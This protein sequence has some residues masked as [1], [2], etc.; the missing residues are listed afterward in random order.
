MTQKHCRKSTHPPCWTFQD[1]QQNQQLRNCASSA[2]V[3]EGFSLLRSSYRADNSYPLFFR[4]KL[5]YVVCVC[6]CI[7][8][9]AA[10]GLGWRG[11][12]KNWMSC[13]RCAY[14]KKI[15]THF[16]LRRTPEIITS[17]FLLDSFN[18]ILAMLRH[19]R[20]N[21]RHCFKGALQARK[22][23]MKTL[24]DYVWAL[25]D[26]S[27]TQIPHSILQRRSYTAIVN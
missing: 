16:L 11:R 5:R 22:K 9:R 10:A 18:R 8:R 24:E 15:W 21:L 4:L 26:T 12:G 19:K 23:K 17:C 7:S 1:P 20:G 14:P 13:G 25:T 6:V 3:R 2:A 27:H